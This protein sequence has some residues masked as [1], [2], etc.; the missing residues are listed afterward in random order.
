M[1]FFTHLTMFVGVC[2]AWLCLFLC[3]LSGQSGLSLLGQKM[4]KRDSIQHFH[5]TSLKNMPLSH[6]A[7]IYV[8]RMN[9]ENPRWLSLQHQ[10]NTECTCF[11]PHRLFC[12]SPK[13]TFVRAT[14]HLRTQR[15]GNVER[16]IWVAEWH[17]EPEITHN[18][19]ENDLAES[20]SSALALHVSRLK[21]KYVD[22]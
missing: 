4:L 14:A 3:I 6:S 20:L 22:W 17:S 12:K 7:Y 19:A 16:Q 10:W 21:K 15:A 18:D 8:L 9:D 5:T 13:H 1:F 2:V 11:Y